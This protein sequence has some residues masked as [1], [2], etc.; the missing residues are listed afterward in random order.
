MSFQDT[1]RCGGPFAGTLRAGILLLGPRIRTLGFISL[2]RQESHTHTH[3]WP[4]CV[5]SAALRAFS[6]LIYLILTTAVCSRRYH[7][8]PLDRWRLGDSPEI[9]RALNES[10]GLSLG[11]LASMPTFQTPGY[12][13]LQGVDYSSRWGP[14]KD[15]GWQ[16]PLR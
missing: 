14:G 4:Y 10:I 2:Q 9:M 3:R 7:Y 11:T 12:P 5:P 8:G 6:G 16:R 13:P 1:W 15:K